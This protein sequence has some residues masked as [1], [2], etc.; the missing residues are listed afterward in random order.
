MQRRPSKLA[1]GNKSLD[2][3][4]LLTGE[5][6]HAPPGLRET[7]DDGSSTGSMSFGSSW[8]TN[9]AKEMSSFS[10]LKAQEENLY[11]C[12]DDVVNDV[13]AKKTSY[14]A[15]NERSASGRRNSTERRRRSS[16]ERPEKPSSGRRKSTERRPP[17]RTSTGKSSAKRVSKLS[18]DEEQLLM[19]LL[20]KSLVGD[21]EFDIGDDSSVGSSSENSFQ[22]EAIMRGTSSTDMMQRLEK[23][24]SNLPDIIDRGKEVER[25]VVEEPKFD[26][27]RTELEISPGEF[28]ILRGSAE[29]WHALERGFIQT[30]DCWGCQCSLDCV[31]D[32]QLVIC[33]ECRTLS[34]VPSLKSDGSDK[35]PVGGVSL[36]V[37]SFATL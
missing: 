29:T 8:K 22:A 31:R 1:H 28:M 20:A 27:D 15:N 5:N 3:S 23:S 32:A 24:I 4:N 12:L 34:P 35:N 18:D 9:F 16:V 10:S 17:R 30:L 13:F 19:H 37:K 33:P 21:G 6:D 26:E 11:P 36:G 2:L 25:E 7:S 14:A